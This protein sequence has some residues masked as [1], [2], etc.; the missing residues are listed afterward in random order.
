MFDHIQGD[1][2]GVYIRISSGVY[3]DLIGI[4]SVISQWTIY[5]DLGIKVPHDL[6]SVG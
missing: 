2:L 6:S 1:D 5:R 4:C 3:R